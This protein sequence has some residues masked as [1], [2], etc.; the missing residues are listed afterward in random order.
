[1]R[2]DIIIGQNGPGADNIGNVD[3][4]VGNSKFLRLNVGKKCC[5]RA[6]EGLVPVE[7]K[8]GSFRADSQGDAVPLTVGDGGGV[9]NVVVLHPIGG[10]RCDVR[11]IIFDPDRQLP[12]GGVSPDKRA[13]DS[14]SNAG[15]YR[16]R[17]IWGGP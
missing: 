16:T 13:I 2:K 7:I 15:E 12:R 3:G 17:R 6:A 14:G 11:M 9:F 4:A 8:L 1:M 5:R 10:A